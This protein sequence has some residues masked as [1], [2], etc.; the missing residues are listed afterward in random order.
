MNRLTTYSNKSDMN[1]IYSILGL[2]WKRPLTPQEHA[3]AILTF[4]WFAFNIVLVA[5]VDSI[6]TEWLLL[7]GA[8]FYGNYWLGRKLPDIEDDLDDEWE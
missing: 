8:S 3:I 4:L 6:P 7:V 1:K 5:G 2:K